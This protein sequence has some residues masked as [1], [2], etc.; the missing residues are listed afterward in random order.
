MKEIVLLKVPLSQRQQKI[1]A[2]D[3]DA[4]QEDV[5]SVPVM[6]SGVLAGFEDDL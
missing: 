4:C 2:K 3:D 6:M 5:K 1:E